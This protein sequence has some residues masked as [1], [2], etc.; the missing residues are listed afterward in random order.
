MVILVMFVKTL[1]TQYVKRQQE[2]KDTDQK[3]YAIYAKEKKESIQIQ[4]E[5]D[6]SVIRK[7]GNELIEKGRQIL[8]IM[9]NIQFI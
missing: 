8:N 4:R 7:I 6:A 9:K 3:F 2:K 5:Y 1:Y